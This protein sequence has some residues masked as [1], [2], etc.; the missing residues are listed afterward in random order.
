MARPLRLEFSGALYHVT[1]RGNR[2]ESIY[3]TDDDR[4]LFLSVLDAACEGFY[5]LMGNHYHLL[6]ET[7]DGNLCCGMRQLNGVY[8]QELQPP[9]PQG[10]SPFPRAV[11]GDSR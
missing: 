10:G 9:A 7:P 6:I 8:T 11:Q 3:E 5:C 1:S 2:R 4:R